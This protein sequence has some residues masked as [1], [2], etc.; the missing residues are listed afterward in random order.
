MKLRKKFTWQNG[1]VCI[2]IVDWDDGTPLGYVWFGTK[3]KIDES[4]SLDFHLSPRQAITLAK[5]ILLAAKK[6]GLSLPI[7][8]TR[9]APSKRG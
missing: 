8:P 2:D 5:N 9:R 3:K 4:P 7:S 1:V 6:A